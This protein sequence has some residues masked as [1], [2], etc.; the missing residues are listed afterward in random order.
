MLY[1]SEMDNRIHMPS[2]EEGRLIEAC[3]CLDL[4]LPKKEEWLELDDERCSSISADF[5]ALSDPIRIRIM[6]MLDH[7]PLYVCLIQHLLDDISNSK[8]S[9][10]LDILKKADLVEGKREGHF[11]L[12]SLSKKGKVLFNE[13]RS[14]HDRE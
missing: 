9:Y 4:G 3:R 11:I 6:D 13:L 5:K 10:H 14:I 7:G 12:Y 8:L 1:I 2:N